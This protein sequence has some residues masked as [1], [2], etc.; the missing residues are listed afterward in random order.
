MDNMILYAA[1]FQVH[2]L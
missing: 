1:S 2:A